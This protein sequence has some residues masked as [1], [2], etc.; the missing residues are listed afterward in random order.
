[1]FELMPY[2]K[3]NNF[4]TNAFQDLENFSKSFFNHNSSSIFQTDIKDNGNC[5]VIETD[6][7][8]VSKDNIKIDISDDYL[9]IKC[10]RN[11]HNNSKS[12][13][14]NYIR[15]ERYSGS[16]SR[17]FDVK[18]VKTDEIEAKYE[19]GVLILELPKKQESSSK[20]SRK[21]NIQ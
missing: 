18:S 2:E 17:S 3:G 11:L 7:P 12:K 20:Q 9:T 8:G 1:M 19:N 10:E 4:F 21:I 14:D 13:L 15:R 16:F 6:I 5:Y